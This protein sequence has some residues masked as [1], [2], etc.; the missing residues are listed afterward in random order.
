MTA[1]MVVGSETSFMVRVPFQPEALRMSLM[2]EIPWQYPSTLACHLS[3]PVL[4]NEVEPSS[5]VVI[6]LDI[7]I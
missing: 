3:S 1:V 4:Q 6:E 2:V 5:R 7:I